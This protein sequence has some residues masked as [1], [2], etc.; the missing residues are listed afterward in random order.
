MHT[1]L[2]NIFLS[3]AA[4]TFGML[5]FP[6]YTKYVPKGGD[7]V[8]GYSWSVILINLVF[9]ALIALAALFLTMKGAFQW[10][11]PSPATRNA[12]VFLGIFACVLTAALSG[13]FR[14][15][16]GP[17]S[18]LFRGLTYF[19]HLLI[20]TVL[21]IGGFILA[22]DALRD[23]LPKNAYQYPL[24]GVFYLGVLGVGLFL[25][26]LASQSNQNNQRRIEEIGEREKSNHE[27]ILAE[28]DSCDVSKNMVFILV[29][30]DA[31]QS[32]DVRQRAVE[33]IKARPD[34]QEELVRRLQSG[35]AAQAFT[36]LASN[37]VDDQ[38]M[39]LEP[40]REGVLNQAKAIRESI[41]RSS[42]P[43]HFYPGLFQWEVDRVIRTVEKMEGK[44]TDYLPAMRELRA[45]FDE[46]TDVEKT[47]WM[48]WR[49][50]TGGS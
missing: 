2:G 18:L 29:F 39:F 12:M 6:L 22:N 49:P 17:M 10:V 30:T 42:H 35:W 7:A 20:P 34:W 26:D 46:P 47:K 40:V 24:T 8:M 28:I 11:S 19:A 31:N 41:R 25:W 43:S 4:V 1:L 5:L 37:E 13:L 50:W 23:A 27:R 45:A 38:N 48:P 15:E 9:F 44:G 32:P 21:V 16:P 33:K 36:F 14:H 3:L